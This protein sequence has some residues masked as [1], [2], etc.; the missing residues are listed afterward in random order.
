MSVSTGST[1]ALK[2][3]RSAAATPNSSPITRIGRGCD[4]VLH[5][6]NRTQNRTTVDAVEQFIGDLLNSRP[7][8]FHRARRAGLAGQLSQPGVVRRILQQHVHIQRR[9]VRT[10]GA[11][12]KERHGTCLVLAEPGIVEQRPGFGKAG[13]PPCPNATHITTGCAG[14]SVRG[15]RCSAC[16]S[17]TNSRSSRT[18]SST[19]TIIRPR[20]PSPTSLSRRAFRLGQR[21]HSLE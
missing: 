4:E 7:Q 10:I 2:L 8:L 1:P 16:G 15:R 6:V 20:T 17:C 5:Q 19:S 21:D 14:A 18:G 12:R 3:S 9:R 13:D 11:R